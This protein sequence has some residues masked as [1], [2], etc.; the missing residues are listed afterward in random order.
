MDSM[1]IGFTGHRDRVA[2]AGELCRIAD[3]HPE[4]VWIHGGAVGFD[5]QVSA[6]ASSCGIP[7]SILRPDYA[8][9]GKS[10]PLIRNRE[11]VARAT[12]LVACWDGRDSG[13]TAHT[14]AEARKRGVR[15][16]VL[17]PYG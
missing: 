10:A 9:H 14:V 13:G 16:E 4:A 6:Y 15:V 7:Q 5:S 17:E 8:K 1:V 2:H 12:L 11:I 3:E